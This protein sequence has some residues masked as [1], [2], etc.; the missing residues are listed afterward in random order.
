MS[1]LVAVLVLACGGIPKGYDEGGFSASVSLS[2]FVADFNLD[3]D[4][5][6]NNE[7]GLSNRIANITSS[8]V[9]GTAF[10]ALLALALSDRYGRLRCWHGFALLWASGILMQI[11]SSGI[12][13]LII[14]ARIWLGFGAGGLTVVSPMFLSEIS[15]AKSRGM[16][17]S[18]FMV[19]LLSFLSLGTS[20]S[21]RL[22]QQSSTHT[23]TKTDVVVLCRL[24]H[25]L[26]R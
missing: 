1:Y 6:K 11:F 5:W 19:F 8:G 3:P 24:F 4:N 20:P 17:V 13:G 26:W 9:L 22:C 7:S 23:S 16:T 18:L 21:M 12:F 15:P 25:K 2:G 14:F 10:G